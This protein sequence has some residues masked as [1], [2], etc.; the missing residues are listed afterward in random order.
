ML[1]RD[2]PSTRFVVGALRQ[3]FGNVA[4]VLEDAPGAW[5]QL[6]SRI[7]RLGAWRTFGQLVFKMAEPLLA[8]PQS[9]RRRELRAALRAAYP[10][11]PLDATRVASVNSAEAR[12]AIQ[13]IA[14]GVVVVNGTRIIGRKTL[15]TADCFVNL[16][17]GITPAYRG[18]HGGYWAL[19]VGDDGN[20][21][22][23]V[24]RVDAGVDTGE[25]L[26]QVRVVPSSADGY[27][28]LPLLQLLHGLPVLVE[29]VDRLLADG[30]L[31]VG[32]PDMPAGS[33]QWYHPTLW[34]YL[35]T[36]VTKGVW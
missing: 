28:T 30:V 22:A 29:V 20:V 33:T 17:A 9:R 4:V 24:H 31:P 32:E 23:T 34:R 36:G 13:A 18:V 10:P 21:G 12:A 27:F 6:G 14:P 11:Q 26:A 25:V 7:A 1:A 2:V 3:R 19:V 5:A 16:H 15:A 35:V 8:L